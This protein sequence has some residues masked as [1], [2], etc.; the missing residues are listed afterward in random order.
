MVMK[1][2]SHSVHAWCSKE[3]QEGGD[4]DEKVG[5]ENTNLQKECMSPY[6]GKVMAKECMNQ[7]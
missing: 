7:E 3:S 6:T 5:T 2:L 4:V 1:A